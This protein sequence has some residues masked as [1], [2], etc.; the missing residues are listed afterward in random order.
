[1]WRGDHVRERTAPPSRWEAVLVILG[2][3]LALPL[4]PS[5]AFP[6]EITF[7]THSTED[8]VYLDEKGEMRGK[9]HEGR[10]AFAVEV[11]RAMME[12]VGRKDKRFLIVPFKRGLQQ[13]QNGKNMALFNVFRRPNR[14]H[15]VKWVGPLQEDISSLYEALNHP[16]D[17]TS[18][19]EARKVDS[20]C[21]LNGNYHHDYLMEKKFSNVVVNTSYANCFR[22]LIIG[23]VDLAALGDTAF[24]G[25]IGTVGI[26]GTAVRPVAEIFRTTGYLIMSKNIPDPVIEQWQNALDELRSNGT[27]HRLEREFLL[28]RIPE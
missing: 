4:F 24:S 23:R 22:M 17:V 21:V 25:L 5:F 15:T 27:Y 7:M 3:I 20:I 18:L 19:E 26:P 6:A 2:S 11:V 14:E 13:V 16:T 28:D 12:R 10:R 1:M 9:P 8:K